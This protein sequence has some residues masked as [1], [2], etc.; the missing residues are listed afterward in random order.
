MLAA[1]NHNSGNM[2]NWDD[3]EA[4]EDLQNIKDDLQTYIY[5]HAPPVLAEQSESSDLLNFDS[6]YVY[7]GGGYLL[8]ALEYVDSTFASRAEEI[9][10]TKMV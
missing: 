8:C 4:L 2:Q 5:T 9:Q 10:T 3:L 1:W 6:M 7:P